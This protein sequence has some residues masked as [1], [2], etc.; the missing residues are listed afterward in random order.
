MRAN[1]NQKTQI[2][3]LQK[4]INGFSKNQSEVSVLFESDS[5]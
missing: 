3:Q 5:T 1:A 2:E 4:K